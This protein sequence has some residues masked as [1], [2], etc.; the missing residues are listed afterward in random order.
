MLVANKNPQGYKECVMY[1]TVFYFGYGDSIIDW[2]ANIK[3]Y[4]ANIEESYK[5]TIIGHLVISYIAYL[6]LYIVQYFPKCSVNE[7]KWDLTMVLYYTVIMY[8]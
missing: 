6:L 2:L 1:V 5:D 7:E 4:V 3:L 8:K